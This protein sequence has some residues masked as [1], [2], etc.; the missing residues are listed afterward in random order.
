MAATAA[1]DK[2]IMQHIGTHVASVIWK[3]LCFERF[4]VKQ[5]TELYKVCKL[6]SISPKYAVLRQPETTQ[7]DKFTPSQLT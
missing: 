2:E 7:V 3:W 6:Y 1:E 5:T 4:K